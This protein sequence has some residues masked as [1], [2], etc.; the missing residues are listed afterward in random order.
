[1]ARLGASAAILVCVMAAAGCGGGD[2]ASA[3]ETAPTSSHETAA[4]LGDSLTFKR[5]DNQE[6]IGT[7]RFLEVAQ[8]P[9]DCVIDPVS[10]QLIGIRVIVDNPGTL[11]L[12]KPDVYDLKVVDGGGFTQQVEAVTV[13]SRCDNDFP[14]IGPSQP[15]GKTT[16]WTFIG[17]RE[18]N[19]ARI[20]YSPMVAE[21]D[22]TL[23]DLKLIAV[24][25]LS[26]TVLMPSPIPA[27]ATAVTTTSPS[28]PAPSSVPSSSPG[29]AA[30]VPC[31]PD[32]DIWAKDAAGGQL[33]CAFAGG[34]TA[35]WVASAPFV[36]TRTPGTPCEL[37][38]AV[39]ETSD[40][41]TLVCVGDRGSSTWEPGP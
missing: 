30:G 18:P 4:K 29:P 3:P 40:G 19:P 39:A 33:R 20:V 36:G 28:A 35:K 23:T 10:A 16:G 38:A 22:S 21:V 27:A 32:S 15:G 8:V 6:F 1:M 37:G 26:A 17:V 9:A 31:D 12:S 5:A 13:K 7:V 25:P 34:P 14:A 11:F 2:K 24:S 41:T